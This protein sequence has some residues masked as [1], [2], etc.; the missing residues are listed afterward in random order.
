MLPRAMKSFSRA[1]TSRPMRA[2][3]I[4]ALVIFLGHAPALAQF[5]AGAAMQVITPDPLLPVS[6]GVGPTTPVKEKRGE[7]SARALV[8]RHGKVTVA[9]VSLD[10][11]GFPS[12]LCD[13]IR[14]A[15]PSIP[16]RNILVGSTHTHSA[17]DCYAFPDGKGGHTGDLNYMNEVCEK[18]ARAVNEAMDRLQPASLKVATGEVKGRVAY[19]YY[20]PDL[21]DRRASVLQAITPSGKTIATLVNYAVHPEVL[22]ASVGIISPDLIGPLC[23]RIESQVGGMAIFMN[24]AQGGMVTADNRDLQRPRDPVRGYWHD[25]RT[26]DEC[27]RIG[28]LLA[29]ESLRIVKDASTQASPQLECESVDVRLPVESDAIWSIVVHSPLKYPR[30]KDRSITSRI[31]LVNVGNAQILTIPGEA[32][33]NIGF[34]L[35]R[36]MQGQHNLLFGLTN[37]AL[38]Y[39]LTRVDYDSF[40]RY[41]YISR[42]SLGEM[43]GEILI[44][45][46]LDLVQQSSEKK[47]GD[48]FPQELV[49]FS[50]YP[51]NPVFTA[52]ESDRWDARIRERGWILRD[53]TG[54]RMWYTGYDGSKQG[55][56]KLGL[57][58]SRDGIQWARHAD[59]PLLDNLW[60]EDMMVIRHA[61]RYYM[62]AEG[63]HDQAQLLESADG[64]NWK[65][66]WRLDVRNVDGQPIEPGPYGTPTAWFENDRWYLFYERRDAGVW[67]A[68]S[69]DLRVW[70]KVQDAPVLAR[71]PEEYDKFAVAMNQIVRHKGRYYAYYHASDTPE[72]REWSTC[73]AVSDDL[74]QW[75]KFSRNPILHN[76]KSSGILVH[77]GKQ[78]RLYTMHDR[79]QVHLPAHAGR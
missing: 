3:S 22:G 59:N 52:S 30:N 14:A 48:E 9:I 5:Q 44:E 19:N 13:R 39:I 24:G 76:N 57:A 77:D 36:K 31:N 41:D 69:T 70:T 4:C 2:F 63:V 42:T 45:A 28:Q 60:V 54:Y 79:V 78:F 40:P 27:V 43:T 17:P 73:V 66:L 21:Y 50:A 53:P 10:V 15:V 26:W 68:T 58:T 11:L 61:D 64:L 62:F 12:V 6:G 1:M 38:G 23:E 16:A 37:D 34:Y 72:W 18:A 65:R 35:K 33:P 74:V 29:D 46:A 56:R 8:L 20:A 55:L 32:L 7:L 49:D 75:R 67:L 71:G 51:H 25:H 47:R